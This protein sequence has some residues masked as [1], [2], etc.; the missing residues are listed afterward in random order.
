MKDFP[1]SG[2]SAKPQRMGRP[3]L[4]VE[5]T[6]IRLAKGTGARIERLVGKSGMARFIRAVIEAEL[7][8]REK[9]DRPPPKKKP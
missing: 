8:R 1:V 7:E 5:A 2:D 6:T 9:H 4:Q 3:P